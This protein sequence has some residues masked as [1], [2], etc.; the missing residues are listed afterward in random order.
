MIGDRN[1]VWM[2]LHEAGNISAKGICTDLTA[3]KC[4]KFGHELSKNQGHKRQGSTCGNTSY[5]SD[6]IQAPVVLVGVAKNPL[7]FYQL[8]LGDCMRKPLFSYQIVF[9]ASFWLLLLLRSSKFMAIIYVC[10]A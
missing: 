2:C 6:R 9:K 4:I 3:L 10:L 7:S 8:C 1:R 5:E